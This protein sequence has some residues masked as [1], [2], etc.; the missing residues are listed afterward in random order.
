MLRCKQRHLRSATALPLGGSEQRRQQTSEGRGSRGAPW[1]ISA[2]ELNETSLSFLR[3]QPRPSLM[4]VLLPLLGITCKDKIVIVEL[5]QLAVKTLV[6]FNFLGRSENRAA[7]RALRWRQKIGDQK[8][9]RQTMRNPLIREA[10][11]FPTYLI[12]KQGGHKLSGLEHIHH[13]PYQIIV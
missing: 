10:S 12:D 3:L 11:S 2:L 4:L 8:Y 1:T 7:F 6:A 13:L 9:S 5:S